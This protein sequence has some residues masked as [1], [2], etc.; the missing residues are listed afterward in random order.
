MQHTVRVHAIGVALFDNRKMGPGIRGERDVIHDRMQRPRRTSIV[1]TKSTIR[2]GKKVEPIR[3]GSV[4][5]SPENTLVCRAWTLQPK[6][7]RRVGKTVERKRRVHE[8]RAVS[9]CELQAQSVGSPRGREGAN[10]NVT[11]INRSCRSGGR[12]IARRGR[13]VGNRAAPCCLCAGSAVFEAIIIHGCRRR[14]TPGI[15]S[16]GEAEVAGRRTDG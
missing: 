3:V 15:D 2:I 9:S 7:Q 11:S 16:E 10:A 5:A 1:E 4:P 8:H 13:R 12:A 6:L 14:S